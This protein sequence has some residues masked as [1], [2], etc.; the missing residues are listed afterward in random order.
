MFLS[1]NIR[2]SSWPLGNCSEMAREQ[3]TV[4]NANVCKKLN[5]E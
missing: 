5:A 1:R 2:P 3:N 4:Q